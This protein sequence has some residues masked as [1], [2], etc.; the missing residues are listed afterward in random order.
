MS[1]TS[2][3]PDPSAIGGV[4]KAPFALMPNPARLFKD[5]A[6]RFEALATGSRLQAYLTFMAG[7]ARLQGE[8][9]SERQAVEVPAIAFPSDEV[10]ERARTASM[11]P[12]DRDG[13]AGLS[14]LRDAVR[15]FCDRAEALAK[16][17]AAAEALGQVKTADDETIDWMI[18]NVLSDSLPVESIAHH[19]FVAAAVQVPMALTASAFD[20]TKLVP[21]GTGA[22]P[23]CGG[24]PEGSMVIGVQG[25]EGARYATCACCSAMWN[26]VRVKCLCCGS[27]KGVGYRA[28]GEDDQAQSASSAPNEARSGSIRDDATVKAEVCD[29]CHSWTKI[30]YQN[31][32]PSLDMVADDVAS[33]GLDLLMKDTEY[34]RGGFSPFLVGY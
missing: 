31:R 21:V 6:G 4:A 18:S 19:L 9:A 8:L 16:P 10:I 27:T 34:R 30:L 1:Q 13:L 11:P 25:A 17:A 26:E 7:L 3:Q 24:K 29:E 32:N 15:L 28:V 23:V 33:L 2:I 14:G 20:A 12:I 22:C 5:R